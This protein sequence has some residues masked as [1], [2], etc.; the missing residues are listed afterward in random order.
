MANVNPF[1]QD[2]WTDV[3]SVNFDSHTTPIVKDPDGTIEINGTRYRQGCKTELYDTGE[4]RVSDGFAIK[5]R[6]GMRDEWAVKVFDKVVH[7]IFPS[8]RSKEQQHRNAESI[9]EQKKD[10]VISSQPFEENRL[11]AISS[12]TDE[13]GASTD[14][15]GVGEDSVISN[16]IN[17]GVVKRYDEN[18]FN[19]LSQEQ[20]NKWVVKDG[21]SYRPAINYDDLRPGDILYN[22]YRIFNTN[23]HQTRKDAPSYNFNESYIIDKYNLQGKLIK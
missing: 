19:S 14:E 15:I 21:E 7:A 20:R 10:Y 4:V 3:C 1:D 11:T 5:K 13:I 8:G 12:S 18:D 2:N 9:L 16:L 17:N 6:V 23:D 22:K